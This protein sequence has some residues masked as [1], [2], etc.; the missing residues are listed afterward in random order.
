M[1]K[2]KI[3]IF[4][5]FLVGILLISPISAESIDDIVAL[6][7][8]SSVNDDVPLSEDVQTLDENA[9]DSLKSEVQDD[10]LLEDDSQNEI[11]GSFRDLQQQIDD[12]E[13][14]L[15]LS[16]DFAYSESI[17]GDYFVDGIYVYDKSITINGNG[18]KISGENSARIFLFDLY[19]VEATLNNLT[20]IGGSYDEGGAVFVYDDSTVYINNVNFSSNNAGLGGAIYSKG[21]VYITDS[22]FDNNYINLPVSAE[23]DGGAA[24]FNQGNLSICNSNITN[25]LKDVVDESN[26]LAG[27]VATYGDTHIEDCYFADNGG[28]LGGA[29]SSWGTTNYGGN[30]LE[31]VNTVFKGNVAKFGGAIYA[32]S[33][34]L[35]IDNCTFEDNLAN[36]SDYY[37]LGGG[38]ILVLPGEFDVEITNTVFSGN[39]AADKGGAIAFNDIGEGTID[40]CTFKSNSAGEG[41]ALYV[42]SST[43]I[44]ISNSRFEANSA[45]NG[46][47]IFNDGELELFNNTFNIADAE[48]YNGQ[49]IIDSDLKI[50][51]F[52]NQTISAEVG[53][54]LALNATFTDDNGNLIYDPYFKFSVNGEEVDEI[55]FAGGLYLC[56]YTVEFPGENVISTGYDY[57]DVEKFISI[58]NVP[59]MDLTN[60]TISSKREKIVEGEML[61]VFISL[62]YT[63]NI[64]A[65]T[66]LKLY[67]NDT[68]YDVPI[69]GKTTLY[70][71]PDLTPGNYSIIGIFDG[72]SMF[73]DA[74]SNSIN[75]TVL[76]SVYEHI[77]APERTESLEPVFSIDLP[78]D[79][80]GTFSVTVGNEMYSKELVNG[81]AN[82]T[83]P[84][85]SEG[86]H[87]VTVT[88]TGDDR[89]ASYS[90]NYNLTVLVHVKSDNLVVPESTINS[91]PVFSINLP[92]NA[93]G[94]FTVIIDNKVYSEDLVNGSASITS[95]KLSLGKH[96]AT[97]AY[98]GDYNYAHYS[99]DFNLTILI[100]S[101]L[102]DI[103]IP[104]LTNNPEPVFSLDIASDASGEFIVDVDGKQYSTQVINGTAKIKIPKLD[105]GEYN[106]TLIYTGDEKYSSAM[107]SSM[108]KIFNLKPFPEFSQNNDATIV[109]SND[110]FYKVLLTFNRQPAVGQTVDIIFNGITYKCVTDNNGYATL[111]I[112]TRIKPNEYAI[113]ARFGDI[114]VSNKIKINHLIKASI[115]MTKSKRIKVVVKLDKVN[116]KFL[117][118]KKVK[119]VFKGK[120]YTLK[121]N[122]KG[123]AKLTLNKKVSSKLKKG[124]TYKYQVSYGADKIIKKF[125]IKKWRLI[126]L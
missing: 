18:H 47:A 95:L 13:G 52:G 84:E 103:I 90:R 71:I 125:K 88:Y 26:K 80:T 61:T 76:I 38:A 8:G 6:E 110:Y 29:I 39:S 68:Q 85:L 20:L 121:T 114:E 15:N 49:G 118:S 122:K 59:K 89:Y 115:K 17:D 119:F 35:E 55:G 93:T 21:E 65:R 42:K 113:T 62:D 64:T 12:A 63:N 57:S 67:V 117:K 46:N 69:T 2:E 45:S 102:D 75:I 10:N 82:I 56:N 108:L 3:F 124:K 98:S 111:K 97:V 4:L 34:N 36:G 32:L 14:V 83:L 99:R 66:V 79:A 123:I 31:I 28:S 25:N 53:D 116:G 81:S 7:D 43:L 106:I 50:I 126:N 44:T 100:E 19:G 11:K 120:K 24:I 37:L 105:D 91:R 70:N 27:A 72:N 87:N 109:Y 107:K 40:N 104:K 1:N 16:Y 112:D 51:I 94:S 54:V 22:V 74:V 48:I 23:L 101:K 73:N 33:F 30:L 41:G 60:F 78:S 58:V 86:E 9:Q 77:I 92:S 5:L 96:N